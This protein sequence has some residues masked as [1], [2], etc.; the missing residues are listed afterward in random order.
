MRAGWRSCRLGGTSRRAARRGPVEDRGRGWS[1]RPRAVRPG[2]GAV[3]IVAGP[4]PAV[5]QSAVPELAELDQAA[6]ELVVGGTLGLL[7]VHHQSGVLHDG[8]PVAAHQE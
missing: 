4:Q 3:N 8:E 6:V 2:S 7:P 5:E 1:I